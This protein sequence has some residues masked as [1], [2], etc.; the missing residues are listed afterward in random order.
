M[1]KTNETNADSPSKEGGK[2]PDVQNITS[3]VNVVG[4]FQAGELKERNHEFRVSKMVQ[5][6]NIKDQAQNPYMSDSEIYAK[7]NSRQYVRA[8]AHPESR[9]GGFKDTR[10]KWKEVGTKGN[11]LNSKKNDQT[12]KAKM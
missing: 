6:Y 4:S 12:Y 3:K 5:D 11:A 10:P 8:M 1:F 7:P 2:S 9:G